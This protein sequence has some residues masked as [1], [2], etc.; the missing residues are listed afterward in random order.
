MSDQFDKVIENIFIAA[1]WVLREAQQL[2]KKLKKNGNV[3][4]PPNTFPH[5]I[6]HFLKAF[7]LLSLNPAWPSLTHVHMQNANDFY[8]ALPVG[9]SESKATSNCWTLAK[10][11]LVRK[12]ETLDE[13]H[14][15]INNATDEEKSM[16][17]ACGLIHLLP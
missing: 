14:S 16:V 6:G 7:H 1:C 10:Q 3:K 12:H 15:S 17:K 5:Y 11:G 4:Y 13:R 8:T 2:K 9:G